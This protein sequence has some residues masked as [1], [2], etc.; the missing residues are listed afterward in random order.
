MAHPPVTTGANRDGL[1]GRCA[2]A[3]RGRRIRIVYPEGLEERAIRAAAL[4]R[5]QDLAA[6][7]VIGPEQAVRSRAG[8]R[9]ALEG[10]VVRDHLR[11]H[12]ARPTPAPTTSC[13]VTRA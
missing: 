3:V 9:R 6:P 2:S 5:D 1:H 4:L 11:D 8:S 10:I 7:T 12:G 13:A